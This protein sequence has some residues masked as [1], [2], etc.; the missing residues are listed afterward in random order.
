MD[1]NEGSVN[2]G[3]VKKFKYPS[4]YQLVYPEDLGDRITKNKK[5]GEIIRRPDFVFEESIR[6]SVQ[7]RLSVSIDSAKE[8]GTGAKKYLDDKIFDA[9]KNAGIPETKVRAIKNK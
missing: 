8:L 1:V 2:E 7:D 3:T 9:Y 6:F 5:T 4:G